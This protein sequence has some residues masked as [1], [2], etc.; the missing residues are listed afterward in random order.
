MLIRACCSLAYQ[1]MQWKSLPKREEG[2]CVLQGM[3][4]YSYVA[5]DN[6]QVNHHCEYWLAAMNNSALC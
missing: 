1:H 2:H 3:G 6:I 4:D 5:L